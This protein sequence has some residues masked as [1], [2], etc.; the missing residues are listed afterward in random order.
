MV[1]WNPSSLQ[2]EDIAGDEYENEVNGYV[3]G[4]DIIGDLVSAVQQQTGMSRPAAI[5]HV[6]R[7]VAQTGPASAA[8][9]I[10]RMPGLQTGAHVVQRIPDVARSQLSPLPIMNLNANQTSTFTWSPQRPFRLERLFLQTQAGNLDFIVNGLTVG[11]DPQ[12]VNNGSLPGTMFLPNSFGVHLKGN[13]ANPGVII[14]I[15]ITNTT[16]AAIVVS[17]GIVGTSLT[18]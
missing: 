2:Y 18:A 5:R 16:G 9:R 13:T 17:G 10:A 3:G 7:Q 14:S 6:Q 12:F 4:N 11:A 8:H 15:E 1:S